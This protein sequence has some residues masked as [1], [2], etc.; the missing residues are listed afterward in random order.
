VVRPGAQ[1]GIHATFN[2]P[3]RTLVLRGGQARCGIGSG[4]TAGAQADAEW[5]EWRHKRAFVERASMP[6]DIVETLALDSGQLRHA[7]EHLTRMQGAAAHF[8][9][10]WP[11]AQVQQCLQQL[12][13][14]HPQGLWRVRLLLNAQGAPHAE[15][16]AM[17]PTPEPVRLQLAAR[18]L[19]EAHGEFV[20]YKTTRRAHYDAFNPTQAGV[21]DTVLWNEEGELTEC[22][23]GNIALLLDGRWVTPAL[24][25]GLLPGVGRALALRTGRLS[26]AVVRLQDL[27]R[28]QDWAFVNSLRGWMAAELV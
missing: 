3:I 10:P 2:V 23:R 22:T 5:A 9:T 26:E 13:Q 25:C 14:A 15:A 4:I 6:F 7:A 19:Q 20:R 21:F 24:H 27:P 12:A 8:G 1:G 16:F 18:P 17:A 28:V 11:A